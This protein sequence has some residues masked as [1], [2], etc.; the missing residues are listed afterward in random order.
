[1]PWDPVFENEDGSWNA[2]ELAYAER[3]ADWQKYIDN[4]QS[5]P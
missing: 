2:P 5:Q 1:M 3:R 4:S